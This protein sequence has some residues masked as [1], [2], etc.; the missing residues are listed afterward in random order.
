MSLL[1]SLVL[2]LLVLVLLRAPLSEASSVPNGAGPT[3]GESMRMR[4][5]GSL[6]RRSGREVENYI[7]EG[8]LCWRQDVAM[9]S[10]QSVTI[11]DLNEFRLCSVRVP[12]TPT[13]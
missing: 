1:L 7:W 8:E 10:A 13:R 2:L 3:R 11:H 6:R 12:Q 5:I 4:D 9:G